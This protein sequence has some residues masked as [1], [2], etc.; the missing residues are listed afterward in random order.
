M[1][2]HNPRI[3]QVFARLPR[4]KAAGPPILLEDRGLLA[5]LETVVAG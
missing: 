3:V 2:E 5:Q 1:R 4:S